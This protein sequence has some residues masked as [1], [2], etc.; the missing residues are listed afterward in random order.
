MSATTRLHVVHA[1][2][3]ASALAG[4]LA[5]ALAVYALVP[6]ST[7]GVVAAV[8][9]SAAMLAWL[10]GVFSR[11]RIVLWIEERVP[12][13]R[14]SLAALVDAPDTPFRP[15]LEAR[16]RASG[17]ARPVV[18]AALKIVAVPVA[19]LLAAHF[20]VAPLLARHAPGLVRGGSDRGD[21][22]ADGPRAGDLRY[23]ATITPPEYARQQERTIDNPIS[24]AAL[25]GSDIRVAGAFTARSTMPA[26]PTVLRLGNAGATRLLALEPRRD[27]TP[28]VV[29]E[30][31]ERD[32][33]IASP[34]GVMRLGA[35]VRDDIGLAAGWFEIIVSSGSGEL[36]ESRTSVIGRTP[37]GSE[38][39]GRLT[40]GLRL[41]SLELKP[42]DVVHLRAVAR[43]NNPRGEPGTSE[44]RTFRVPRP[45][46]NDSVAI[47]AMPPPEVN[48]SE[49]SQ[50]MLIIL[51]ERLVARIRGISAEALG[52]ESSRIAREQARLRKRVGEII[53]TRLTGAE[54]VE[55]EVDA[56]MSDTLSP[57]EAL[58][59]AAS[60]ATNLTEGHEH[61][62]GGGGAVVGV[63]R[64]LLEAFNA[65]WAAERQLGVREPRQALPH[66]RAALD[67]IQRARAA[68]RLYLRGRAP[69]IVLDVARLRLTGKTDGI[70][71][72]ARSPRASALNALLARRARFGSAIDM[73]TSPGTPGAA[74]AIDSL[75]LMRVDALD[76]SPALAAALGAAVDDLRAG[77]D[78]TESLLAVHRQ[79]AGPAERARQTRWSGSW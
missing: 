60:D 24:I 37:L 48:Q 3:V 50:R 41:D 25:V 46:D 79:L 44:T 42:G 47:E 4:A 65:M 38:R 77:R 71:P 31:P 74:A 51:T 8:L 26:E 30:T 66:M 20:F 53:F 36:F 55:E 34:T 10:R 58:L 54:H 61:E 67:A 11:R 56:A 19:A 9:V 39:A 57:G 6:R 1:L 16:V 52:S 72:G 5:A 29:L 23:R 64:N 69:R 35:Q 12:T 17:F 78:A 70:D 43:D 62:E 22:G 45:A 27:S 75:M 28:I 76:E 32:T 18:L 40:V 59:K 2:L 49:L 33:V 15:A 63:N 68:E 14:Y 7:P 21:R 73:L 13:L